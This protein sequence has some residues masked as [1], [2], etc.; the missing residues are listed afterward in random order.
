MA[1]RLA[2][3]CPAAPVHAC[4][5]FS[6]LAAIIRARFT[7][8]QRVS[9]KQLVQEHTRPRMCGPLRACAHLLRGKIRVLMSGFKLKHSPGTGVTKQS[10]QHSPHGLLQLQT[11]FTMKH[12]NASVYIC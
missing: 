7:C 12:T 4:P 11:L 6:Q 8:F 9:S 5:I 10:G 2:A 1:P 3:P